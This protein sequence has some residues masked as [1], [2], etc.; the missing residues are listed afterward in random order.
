VG[1]ELELAAL[2]AIAVI[3]QATFAVF[4]VE[5]PAW[6]KILKWSLVVG[7]TL[8]LARVAGHWALVLPLAAGMAGVIGHTI[9]G[10]RHGLDP[11]RGPPRRRYYDLRGWDRHD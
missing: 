5:T 8:G 1:I 3:G 2:L 6:R 9:C 7:L 4:E 11:I 10:R